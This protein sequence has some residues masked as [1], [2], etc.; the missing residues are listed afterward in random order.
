VKIAL[1]GNQQTGKS[2][3]MSR[4]FSNECPNYYEA[5]LGVE[6]FNKYIVTKNNAPLHITFWDFSGKEDF[7]EIRN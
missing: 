2:S 1:V 4:Y 6:T 3:L 7:S 5:T